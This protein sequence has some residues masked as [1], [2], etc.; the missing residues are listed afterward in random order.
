MDE[1]WSDFDIAARLQVRS[2][3]GVFEVRLSD[4]PGDI[5]RLTPRQFDELRRESGVSRRL[6]G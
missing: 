3:G 5:R 6:F 1:G 4:R 2:I